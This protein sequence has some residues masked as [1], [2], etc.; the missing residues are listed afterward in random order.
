MSSF[1][2]FRAARWI[3]TFN[4][5]LQAGLFLTFFFGLNYLALHHAWRFD[6]TQHR[7]YSLSPETLSWLHNLDQPVRVIV[8][9]PED[10]DD[11]G[12]AAELLDLRGLLREYV[13]ATATNYDPKTHHDGRVTAEYL[14]V[15]QRRREADQLGI[16]QPNSVLLLCGDNR[17]A[18]PL[19]DLYRFKDKV[20]QAFQGEQ[21]ITAALLDVSSPAPKKIYFLTGHGEL[22]PDD[23]DPARGLSALRDELRLRNFALDLLD[24][25]TTRRVPDDA[26]LVIAAA[27][28]GVEPFVQEQLRQYLTA[29]AGR[30]ILLVGPG[31]AHGLDNLLL[32]DWGVLV[33]DDLICDTDPNSVAENGDLVLKTYLAHPITQFLLSNQIPLRI[34]PARSVQAFPG[35]GLGLTVTTLVA[36]SKTAWGEHSYKSGRAAEYNYGVDLKGSAAMDHRLGVMVASERVGARGNLDFSVPRGRLIVFGSADLVTN[37]R[38]VNTGNQNMFFTAVNWA[39]DRDTQL[40]IPARP[41]ERFQL[42]LSAAD[43]LKLRY[44]L[45]LVLPGAAALLGIMV[46]WTRRR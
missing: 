19:G 37:N 15:Y 42:S 31:Q 7:H 1:D 9:I 40:N 43:L 20:R 34:G 24:V 36:T 39:V 45:L 26:A 38:L 25:T 21:A 14:D 2:S 44:S 27:P 18:V 16:D 8:T 30:L 13:Y 32:D 5:V 46:Y 11:A 28:V 17:R 4:L 10:T 33:D 41:I 12:L 23:P 35:P 3:R 29:R 22:R 6:L